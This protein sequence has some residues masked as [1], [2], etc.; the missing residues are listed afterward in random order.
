MTRIQKQSSSPNPGF[1]CCALTRDPW[2]H[3]LLPAGYQFIKDS[4]N[5]V[6]FVLPKHIKVA[7]FI[8]EYRV[9]LG[10]TDA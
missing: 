7:S 3:W 1:P 10:E 9:T 8:E 4:V 5:A 2:A 6:S